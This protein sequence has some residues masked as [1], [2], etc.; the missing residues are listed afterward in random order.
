MPSRPRPRAASPTLEQSLLCDRIRDI[1]TGLHSVREVPMFGGLSFMVDEKMIVAAQKNGDLLVHVD[2][3]QSDNLLG[4]PGT[5]QAE[6]GRGRSMGP[7]WLVAEG[8]LTPK[9]VAFWIGVAM[10]YR[11]R[12]SNG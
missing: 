6:M 4:R 8:A 9:Q 10:E 11:A 2:P 12:A 7:S 3:E 1:L 5:R